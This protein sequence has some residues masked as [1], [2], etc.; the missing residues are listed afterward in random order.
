MAQALPD[1]WAVTAGS[2]GTQRFVRFGAEVTADL[3]FAP[4]LTDAVPWSKAEGALPVDD[5]MAWMVDY[6][7]AVKA[8]MAITVPLAADLLAD[9]RTHGL[10]LLAVGVRDETAAAGASTLESLLRAH[11]YTDGLELL[12]SGHSDQQHRRSHC[13]LDRG[14]R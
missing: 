6:V 4:Q 13:G 7:K 8:G 5:G 1:R 9:I 2:M 10:T 14:D 12:P 3:G 11:L